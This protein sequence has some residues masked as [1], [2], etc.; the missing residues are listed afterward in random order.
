M[1]YQL[2]AN[3]GVVHT[4]VG[5]IASAVTNII[6]DPTTAGKTYEFVGYVNHA[7]LVGVLC[8]GLHSL[9]HL[10]PSSPVPGPTSCTTWY[11]TSTGSCAAPATP[12]VLQNVS[13]GEQ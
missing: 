3:E 11:T 1:R 5:D 7:F 6:S 13:F 12:S 9:P 2:E 4:Q 10:L 8:S